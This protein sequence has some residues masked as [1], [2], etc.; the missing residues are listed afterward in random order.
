MKNV[1]CY[2][3]ASPSEQLQRLNGKLACDD[4]MAKHKN[5]QK[6]RDQF[7]GLKCPKCSNAMKPGDISVKGSA[8]SFLVF[9][10]SHMHCMYDSHDKSIQSMIVAAPDESKLG[11]YCERCEIVLIDKNV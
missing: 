5:G 3:C 6:A 1:K 7:N 2:Y 9:G 11:L 8:A 10:L 4:C